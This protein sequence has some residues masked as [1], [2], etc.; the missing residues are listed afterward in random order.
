TDVGGG[1]STPAVVGERIYL[2]GDDG[3]T[4]SVMALSAADGKL[5][6]K[7]EI[8][9]VGP[10]EGPQYLGSR[11]T[12]TIDGPLLFALGS[13]GDFF[14]LDTESGDVRWSKDLRTDFGGQPGA[15]AYSE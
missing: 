5:I 6:W 1:Y 12:P 13:D 3:K 14:C 7:R 11:S 9:P 4:E 15:W 10:N 8:G 2:L